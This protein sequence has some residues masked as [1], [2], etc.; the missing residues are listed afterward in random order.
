MTKRTFV[1][2]VEDEYDLESELE[3]FLQFLPTDVIK[4]HGLIAQGAEKRLKIETQRFLKQ[5]MVD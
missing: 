1:H 2:E 3:V 4:K 5:R